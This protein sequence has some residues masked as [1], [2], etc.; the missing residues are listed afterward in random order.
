[1][2]TKNNDI[3]PCANCAILIELEQEGHMLAPEKGLLCLDCAL[4]FNNGQKPSKTPWVAEP[5]E[6]SDGRRIAICSPAGDAIV[7]VIPPEDLP[8][9]ARD[10]TEAAF[11]IKAA[12]SHE[13]LVKAL[14]HALAMMEASI[15]RYS[16]PARLFD[17]D[18]YRA[19]LS[20][21]EAQSWENC[22]MNAP[23]RILKLLGLADKTASLDDSPGAT[24]TIRRRRNL[25]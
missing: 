1:L 13:D 15:D 6:A 3:K 4:W 14:E 12:N 20:E 11:L 17:L 25:P 16:D 18:H 22:L 21:A 7:A 2:V 5:E 10:W 9:D 19:V 23:P 8:A 24:I